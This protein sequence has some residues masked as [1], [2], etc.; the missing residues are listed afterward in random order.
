MRVIGAPLQTAARSDN[1]R[2]ARL[3]A[4]ERER[5]VVPARTG[6]RLSRD[7]RVALAPPGSERTDV[8]VL[9]LR[10]EFGPGIGLGLVR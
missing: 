3:D 7:T 8:V 9:E 1:T 6:P 5:R 4:P 10:L 2:L